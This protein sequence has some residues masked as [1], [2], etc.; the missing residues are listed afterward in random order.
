MLGR[1][2]GLSP[3]GVSGPDFQCWLISLVH[4][5]SSRLGPRANA[6]K[7]PG[8]EA[9]IKSLDLA[10]ARSR[11]FLGKRKKKKKGN[12]ATPDLSSLPMVLRE[13][14]SSRNFFFPVL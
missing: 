6:E 11:F 9:H 2:H 3:V 1:R 12:T 7:E 4:T 5:L 13:K 10:G 8:G 14:N